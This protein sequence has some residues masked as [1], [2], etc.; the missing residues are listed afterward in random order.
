M[1][2]E[3]QVKLLRVLEIGQLTRVGGDQPTE[4]DVRVITATNRDP[5][6]AVT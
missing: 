4:V 1:P 6:A 5:A 2:I 3:L